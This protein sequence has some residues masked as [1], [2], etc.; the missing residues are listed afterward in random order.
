[1]KTGSKQASNK[2][3][4]N[5]NNNKLILQYQST[6]LHRIYCIKNKVQLK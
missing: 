3:N 4:N 1:M 6:I 5:D 2:S